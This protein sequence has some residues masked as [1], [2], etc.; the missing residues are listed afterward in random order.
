[1]SSTSGHEPAA[2]SPRLVGVFYP[3]RF[4]ERAEQ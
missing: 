3:V 4:N 2:S 1:M